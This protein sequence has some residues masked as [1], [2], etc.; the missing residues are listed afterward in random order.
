MAVLWGGGE[1]LDDGGLAVCSLSLPRL[2]RAGAVS[3]D[4][5]DPSQ[6]HCWGWEGVGRVV[7]GEMLSCALHRHPHNAV[8]AVRAVEGCI[9]HLLLLF[10]AW[11]VLL[12]P[13]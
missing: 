4:A 2:P 10:M 8:S 6:N 11:A 12:E 13:P 3:S 9:Q 1:G 7:Q 5:R